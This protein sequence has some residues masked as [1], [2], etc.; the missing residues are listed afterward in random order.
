MRCAPV[1][2]PD[3][4]SPRQARLMCVLGRLFAR[5]R[6]LELPPRPTAPIPL[7]IACRLCPDNADEPLFAYLMAYGKGNPGVT[8]ER[9]AW[10]VIRDDLGRVAGGAMVAAMG[11]DHPVSIDVAVDPRR[12]AEGW[13][14]RLYEALDARGIDM[15]A[16]SAASLAHGT[17]TPDG[18]RF[19]R[20][21]RLQSDRDAEAKIVATANVCP[22]CGP[23][24]GSGR[25][26]RGRSPQIPR[27]LH[28]WDELAL[29]AVRPSLM[30]SNASCPSCP[31]TNRRLSHQSTLEDPS[32]CQWTTVHTTISLSFSSNSAQAPQ[33]GH[34]VTRSPSSSGTASRGPL[35]I[36]RRP[37]SGRATGQVRSR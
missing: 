32:A 16:G 31:E 21:R 27:G 6:P 11:P 20:A 23:V 17:M 36:R 33:P 4:R 2:A 7:E 29:R 3:R 1:R 35:S 25:A 14:S 34:H 24:D 18:Y 15:E 19:M 10:W 9:E 5:Q 13:A 28:K 8:Q 12:H 22:G 26:I 30:S 37:G